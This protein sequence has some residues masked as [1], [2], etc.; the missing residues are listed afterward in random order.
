MSHYSLVLLF[1]SYTELMWTY[2]SL[3]ECLRAAVLLG[4]DG[5]CI[6][7]SLLKDLR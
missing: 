1:E 7:V 2:Q 3:H 6:D 5:V 4:G